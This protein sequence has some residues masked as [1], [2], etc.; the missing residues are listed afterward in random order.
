L[1]ICTAPSVPDYGSLPQTSASATS[2]LD[3]AVDATMAERSFT[4]DVVSVLGGSGQA[5]YHYSV[6]YRAPDSLEVYPSHLLLAVTGS[7]ATFIKT[8]GDNGLWS[9]TCP[10]PFKSGAQPATQFLNLLTGQVSVQG[11]GN[12]FTTEAIGGSVL[13]DH[14][15]SRIDIT[16]TIA[17]GRIASEDI[18]AIGPP[19][20]EL[21]ITYSAY[22]SSPP[23]TLPSAATHGAGSGCHRSGWVAYTPSNS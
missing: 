1:S 10:N 15:G 8:P 18:S 20:S 5:G 4:V 6:E 2:A 17:N 21:R 16:A 23:L 14:Q 3:Q 19:T 11:S 12:R 9:E 22:D 13:N 7:G